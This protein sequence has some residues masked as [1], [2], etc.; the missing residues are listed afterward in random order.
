MTKREIVQ[1]AVAFRRPPYVPWNV[2]FTSGARK[3]MERVLGK[4]TLDEFCEPH[5]F[6]CPGATVP[7]RTDGRDRFGTKYARAENQDMGAPVD[8]P[9]KRPEDL[10]SYVW[11]EPARPEWCAGPKQWFGDLSNRYRLIMGGASLFE[12]AWAMR[13]MEDVLA[14]MVERPEFVEE[15]LDAITDY[16]LADLATVLR[17]VES[18]GVWFGD[19]YGMQ[20]GLIMGKPH[21]RRLI[22]PRLARLFALARNEGRQVYIHSC[23]KVDSILEDLIEIGLNI[24]NPFQPEVM[25]VFSVFGSCRGRLS[26]AGGLGVQSVLPHGTQDEVRQATAKLIELGRNGGLIIE[27]SHAVTNDVPPENVVAMMDVLKAQKGYAQG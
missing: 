8:V 7:A 13:S 25:D 4:R 26:F 3:N 12:R 2:T 17:E 9:L 24:F 14:D 19:D 6:M 16:H 5:V 18:E 20:S 23:G 1:E 27:P 22:K 21:W 11:P 10:A 15:L